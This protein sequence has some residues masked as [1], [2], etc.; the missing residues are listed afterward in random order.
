MRTPRKFTALVLMGALTASSVA[1]VPASAKTF[2]DVPSTHWAYTVIDEIS[3]ETIMVGVG[4]GL[5]SPETKLTRAEYTAILFNLAPDKANG[6]TYEAHLKDVE[7]DAWYAEAAE[8]GV[9]HGIIFESDGNFEPNKVITRESM[10][11]MTYKYLS[12]YYPHSYEYDP[13]DAGYADQDQI[14]QSCKS[15]VNVLTHNGLLA[16][17]GNNQFVPEGSLTRAEAAAMGSRLMDVAEKAA[18]E[19]PGEEQPPT[20]DPDEEQPP[21][22]EPDNP[23]EDN[24]GE[25]NP[26][27]D[28]DEPEQ[29]PV[30][31]PDDPADEEPAE[32]PNDP[33]NWDLDGAPKWFLV[34]QPKGYI[35]DD[36][37]KALITYYEGKERPDFYPTE[38]PEG[39]VGEE[40]AKAYM[41]NYMKKLYDHMMQEQA[42]I[43][44]D[45]DGTASL[46]AEEKKMVDLVNNAR[47]DAG[48]GELK[49]SAAL[50]EAASIRAKEA[51]EKTDLLSREEF[52]SADSSY[53]HSR[54][55][56]SGWYTVFGETALKPYVD[57]M[58]NGTSQKNYISSAENMT[59]KYNKNTYSANDAFNGLY[60][61]SPHKKAMLNKSYTHVGV[62]VD[63]STG[64]AT[65]I[66]IF[67]N[68][69]E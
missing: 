26:S 34:G 64:N 48:A 52:N 61:S 9:T 58:R 30:D 66:Q 40:N 32:D 6:H 13:S 60:S 29:P 36:Q 10:A 67:S 14:D 56:G 38:I 25:D 55:D 69:N 63:Y 15:S 37:W 53:F 17:R 41:S 22:E 12:K 23:G 44:L 45:E 18:A 2:S 1:A 8:W 21:V 65:W 62:A 35:T 59:G 54:L 28:P 31:E 11:D 20:E 51:G 47:K 27:V 5:F 46:S 4:D 42:Q 68:V 49:V 16:G 24:P 57:S 50:C 43:V 19:N 7:A 39:L 3:N 33:A